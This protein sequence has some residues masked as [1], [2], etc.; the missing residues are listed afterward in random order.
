MAI[1]YTTSDLLSRVRRTCQLRAVNNKLTD[2]QILEVCDEE[3]QQN[4]FPQLMLARDD[5]QMTST[6]VLLDAGIVRYRVPFGASS[7]TVDHVSIVTIAG[8]TVIN[9][10]LLPRLS[11]PEMMAF[12]VNSGGI[13]RAYAI[14][15]DDI[16]IG[17]IPTYDAA[18]TQIMV[19]HH[20]YRPGRLTE[21]ANCRSITAS[22]ETPPTIT[23]TLASDIAGTGLVVGSAVDIV[24]NVPP[25]M[26]YVTG[27][28]I[29]SIT[30]GVTIEVN[31]SY[32][33]VR[34]QLAAQLTVG[35]YLTPHGSTCVW[36][37]PDAWWSAGILSCSA[38]V[39]RTTGGSTNEQAGSLRADADAA[40][41]RCVQLQT[42]RVRKQ[43]QKVFDRTSPIRRNR[44]GF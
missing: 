27:A 39:A 22:V 29:A 19:I 43:P 8:S 44:Y 14:I 23:I 40:I 34:A 18:A 10:R 15:G 21:V 9:E 28:S 26:P 41:T 42:S 3:I 25:F 4:L 2:A 5:Y 37:L 12:S 6:V 13:P 32:S 33:V 1:T 7:S 36:P 11:A 38:S 31:S 20:E 30:A 35:S 17:P 24:P 16:Q